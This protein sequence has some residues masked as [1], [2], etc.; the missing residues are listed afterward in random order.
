MHRKI[1]CACARPSAKFDIL[2]LQ[3]WPWQNDST[4]P[5]PNPKSDPSKI[6]KTDPLAPDI[7][8]PDGSGNATNFNVS[9]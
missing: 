3:K 4:V 5:P 7:V 1:F 8:I 9:P 6:M 2:W